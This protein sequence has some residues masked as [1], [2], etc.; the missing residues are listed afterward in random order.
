[1]DAGDQLIILRLMVEIIEAGE[2]AAGQHDRLPAGRRAERDQHRAV[3]LGQIFRAAEPDG[4]VRDRA[5]AL[6]DD[7][8]D[9]PRGAR[10]D[11]RPQP[12]L[13]DQR[14]AALAGADEVDDVHARLVQLRELELASHPPQRRLGVVER[15]FNVRHQAVEVDV[16]V[17]LA[18]LILVEIGRVD[19]EDLHDQG[20]HVLDVQIERHRFVDVEVRLVRGGEVDV[21]AFLQLREHLRRQ[22]AGPTL[23]LA[24][25][26]FDLRL[27][28]E[29]FEVLIV[30]PLL[31]LLGRIGIGQEVL[32]IAPHQRLV[33]ADPRQQ[34]DGGI[35]GVQIAG[36]AP[37]RVALQ[38]FLRHVPLL[39][40]QLEI[41][42]EER[43]VEAAL[44]AVEE[45]ACDRA[46]GP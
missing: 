2:V 16:G 45:R 10:G 37:G 21:D 42:D 30:D 35:I 34:R 19:L 28:E 32:Q 26:E 13:A 24:Q 46:R 6:I 9:L 38:R 33:A 3:L 29:V 5:I 14:P 36:I 20:R 1:M 4:R 43:L 11:E 12:A 17:D 41:L 8:D 7:G 18:F 23:R 25:A 15:E 39:P 44:R 40:R 31:E 27:G 22:I